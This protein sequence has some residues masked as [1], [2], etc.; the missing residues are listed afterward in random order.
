[1]NS[2]AFKRRK[3]INTQLNIA[4]LIDIVFLLLIFFILSFNFVQETGFKIKLPKAVNA[5][6]QKN[7]KII[8]SIDKNN[9]IFLDNHKIQLTLLPNTLKN[10]ISIKK[11][12][13]VFI[14]ADETVDIGFVVKIMDIIKKTNTENMIIS[15]KVLNNEKN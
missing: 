15:T 10:K 11:T 13:N 14:Q 5:T 1:M 7:E 6:K 9:D 12:K 2:I 4:P 3:Q 8:L